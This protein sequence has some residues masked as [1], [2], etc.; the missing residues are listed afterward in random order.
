M[1]SYYTKNLPMGLNMYDMTSQQFVNDSKNYIDNEGPLR[2][3]KREKG[4]FD[5]ALEDKK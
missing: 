5:K 3:Q 4:F 1:L 2:I